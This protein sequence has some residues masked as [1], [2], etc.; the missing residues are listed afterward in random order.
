MLIKKSDSTICFYTKQIFKNIN[1]LNKCMKFKDIELRTAIMPLI[2][3]NAVVFLLQI[4]I[5]GFT[6]SF[7]LVGTD[8]FTRPW[9]LLTSMFLHGSPLH[10]FF[11]MY[12]LFLFGTML[13]H[14]IR[15][16]KFLLIYFLSGLVASFIS[17]FFYTRA[18][19]ASGAIYG[20]LGAIVV[21]I[22]SIKVLPLFLPIPM[23]LW[24][25]LII[26]TIIDMLFFSNIA[27]IAHISGA[28]CG[29][30]L[31]L[32]FKQKRRDYNRKFYSQ[33][34]IGADDIEDYF[35]SGRI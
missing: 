33:T 15:C 2:I 19:G 34:H 31:G 9:I 25:A 17:S 22:P 16:R 13:E 21:L 4:L 35:R 26:F 7:M 28:V 27:V 8:I 24:K 1:L 10:L 18:L 12:V 20:I 32:Y 29:I 23:D 3:V 6:E 5:D 30:L 14:E 11:N